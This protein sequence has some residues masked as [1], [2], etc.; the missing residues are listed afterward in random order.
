MG[1]GTG[2]GG[3]YGSQP[4][5]RERVEDAAE[6]LRVTTLLNNRLDDGSREIEHIEAAAKLGSK[7]AQEILD[8]IPDVPEEVE[9]LVE[10]TYMLH[11]RSGVGFGGAAPLSPPVIESWARLMD[12]PGLLPMEVEALMYLDTCLHSKPRKG[13][14][15]TEEEREVE[16]EVKNAKQAWPERKDS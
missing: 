14:H 10:W 12:V 5:F 15:K 2:A 13:K 16:Q 4:F 6:H 8:G 1:A 7:N 9:Y 11:G 3:T